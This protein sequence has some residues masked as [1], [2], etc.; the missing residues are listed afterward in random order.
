MTW[1]QPEPAWWL[2]LRKRI[3]RPPSSC[4]SG[5]RKGPPELATGE[6]RARLWKKFVDLGSSAFSDASAAL[7]SRETALVILEP[8]I[9]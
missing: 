7:R 5:A 6:E 4:S 8:R 9:E 1:A 2:N 3:P